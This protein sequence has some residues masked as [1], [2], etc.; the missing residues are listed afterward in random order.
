MATVTGQSSKT[1]GGGYI[2]SRIT[3][4]VSNNVATIKKLEVRKQPNSLTDPTKGTWTYE[5]GYNWD[6]VQKSGSVSKS[7][8]TSWVTLWSGTVEVKITEDG[9]SDNVIY[10]TVTA[11][12]GTS[13]AG[14]SARA[15]IKIKY[16]E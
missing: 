7:I 11:P 16:E 12:T 9:G 13:Y 4:E 3:Y 1:S 14:L 8:G 15:A 5:I 6:N 2:E 10:G